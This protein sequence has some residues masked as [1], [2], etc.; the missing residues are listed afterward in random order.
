MQR[1]AP[2]LQ[3]NQ[4]LSPGRKKAQTRAQNIYMLYPVSDADG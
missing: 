1:R 2:N 4:A 3:H